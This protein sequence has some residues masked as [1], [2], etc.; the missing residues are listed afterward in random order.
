MPPYATPSRK[1]KRKAVPATPRKRRTPFSSLPNRSTA[2]VHNI[3]LLKQS[4]V[5][6]MIY[7]EPEATQ[8]TGTGCRYVLNNIHDSNSAVG[9][10]QP[11]GFDDVATLY[12]KYRVLSCAYKIVFVPTTT[13]GAP[14][15]GFRTYAVVTS[16]GASTYP[17]DELAYAENK[18]SVVMHRGGFYSTTTPQPNGN[19]MT[20]V[21]GQCNIKSFVGAV[22]NDNLEATINAGPANPVSLHVSSYTGNGTLVNG[23]YHVTLVYKVLLFDPKNPS[24]S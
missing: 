7:C 20:M 23:S 15:R 14:I 21:K 12:S 5:V 17:G 6:E 2:V 19:N 18:S 13:S 9:G 16:G 8:L 4:Q 11:R 1:R 22:D 10:H 24:E 3:A